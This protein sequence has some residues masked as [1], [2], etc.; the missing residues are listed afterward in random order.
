MP[1]YLTIG[2]GKLLI[3]FDADYRLRDLYYPHVGQENHLVGHFSRTGVW[4]GQ[5]DGSDGQFSWF[6]DPSWQRHMTYE[7]DTLLTHV[8]MTNAALGISIHATD[9]VDFHES[10][11]IRQFVISQSRD[12]ARQV[13]L[14]FHHDFH[15]LETAVG[16]TAYYEPLRRAMFHYKKN[17]WF[18]INGL[19]EGAE[20]E[21]IDQWAVGVKEINGQEGTWRDAEDGQLGG[22]PV[23]QGSVDSTI[24][25]H[26]DLPANGTATIYYWM[27]VGKNFEDV[28][29]INHNIRERHIKSYLERTRSFWALWLN[30]HAPDFANLPNAVINLYKSSL[31]IIRT[32]VDH[33]GAVIAANDY[34]ITQFASDTYSYMWPRDGALVASALDQAGHHT[35]TQKFFDFCRNAITPEGY[36]LHKYNPD[37]TLASSWHTWFRDGERQLPVQEDETGLVLW[38][39]WRH[40]DKCHDIEWLSPLF[41]N[42]IVRAADWMVS[43]LDAEGLPEPSWDLWEERRGVHAFT[44][45]AV[46]AGLQAAANFCVSF[47]E[48]EL[49]DKYRTAAEQLKQAVDSHMYR[50]DA[51]DGVPRFVRMVIRTENAVPVAQSPELHDLKASNEPL[52]RGGVV[53]SNTRATQEI[54]IHDDVAVD[55][56]L[57]SAMYGL[58]AFGMYAP[59]DP[60]IVSMMVILRE[61][62]W[63]KT[64]VGGMA[65]YENDYY[66]QVSQDVANVP[67]NPWFICT[68]WLAQY[69]IAAA[70]T[71]ADLEPAIEMLEWTAAHA[72][73]SGILAEQVNPYTHAP[74][75]VSPLTWS[76]ATVIMV[77]HE[78][79]DKRAQLLS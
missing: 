41:R 51:P 71:L 4:I 23:A 7:Q 2:N 70:T 72:L 44:V 64:D 1:R 36:L 50:T 58:W 69:T 8:D 34:D 10:L 14:F 68:L 56:T 27:A 52:G 22:N 31:L 29:L 54:L 66:H 6:D 79:L 55:W 74:I 63:C 21:G 26:A 73:D 11:F 43:Y 9:T 40:Y 35:L 28:R 19:C 60:R 5:A 24:A 49:A 37:G 57:D 59:D 32:Q 61:R 53:G 47:G 13:R 17:R 12:K 75:S 30:S 62:L 42:L 76:H 39:L 77:V 46:W 25:L 65:R 67:G 33:D 78:Y 45:G 48:K 20:K 18:M 15:I 38:S 16:D 3:N